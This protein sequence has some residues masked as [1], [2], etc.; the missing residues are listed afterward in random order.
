MTISRSTLFSIVAMAAGLGDLLAGWMA[1]SEAQI[2][3]LADNLEKRVSV[4]LPRKV[5]SEPSD[6]DLRDLIVR[7]IEE[8]LELRQLEKAEKQREKARRRAEYTKGPYGR[9]NFKVNWMA[10]KL[11]LG[12]EQTRGYCTR[13][14]GHAE[15]V[16][17]LREAADF[18]DPAAIAELV[19]A[20]DELQ[21]KFE[22]AFSAEL[23]NE[24]LERYRRL[25][26][27]ERNASV[28][29]EALEK[30]GDDDL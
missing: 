28:G 13:L 10:H 7:V 3:S 11:R 5:D 20:R 9:F 23:D 27:I 18:S 26:E 6:D 14:D 1:S 21:A 16:R 17:G 15:L 24:Q 8:Q 19:A 30:V 2:E 12:D 22:F 4:A 25:T 29:V